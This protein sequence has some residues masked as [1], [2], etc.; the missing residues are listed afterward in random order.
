MIFDPSFQR[1]MKVFWAVIAALVII[2]MLI[3]YAPGL[4]PGLQ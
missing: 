3:L 2:S 4:I 1:K